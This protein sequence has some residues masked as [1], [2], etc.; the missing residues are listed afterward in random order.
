MVVT[1]QYFPRGGKKPTVGFNDR[2]KYDFLGNADK[3]GKK[4]KYKPKILNNKEDKDLDH[5]SDV[6]YDE[7]DGKIK[8]LSAEKLTY[9]TIQ[10]GMVILGRISEVSETKLSMTLPNRL[11]GSVMACHVSVSYTKLLQSYVDNG[12]EDF[13][14]LEEIY[15][16]GEYVSVKVISVTKEEYKVTIGLSMLPKDVNVGVSFLNVREGDIVRGAVES[17][18]DHGY[19][20]D[21]GISNCRSFLPSK[22]V[23]KSLS[24]VVGQVIWCMVKKGNK[25]TTNSILTLSNRLDIMNSN[26]ITGEKIQH[27]SVNDLRPGMAVDFYVNKPIQDGAEGYVLANSVGYV[28]ASQIDSRLHTGKTVKAYLLYLMP[29]TK[30]PFFTTREIFETFQPDI[31]KEMYYKKGH[32]VENA[33]VSKVTFSVVVFKFENGVGIMSKKMSNCSESENLFDVY[34]TGSEHEIRLVYYHPSDYAYVC[35]DKQNIL[36]QKYFTLEDL[37]VGQFVEGVVARV[38]DKGV[39]VKVDR[40]HGWIPEMHVA[41]VGLHQPEKLDPKKKNLIMKKFKEEDLT[42]LS[43]YEDAKVGSQYKGIIEGIF[44]TSIL[45]K[46][47][48]EVRAIV[49]RKELSHENIKSIKDVFNIGEIVNCVVISVNAQ[50]QKMQGS[51]I[52]PEITL[53]QTEEEIQSEDKKSKRKRKNKSQFSDDGDVSSPPEISKTSEPTK[54]SKKEKNKKAILN[55]A[56]DLETTDVV[57]ATQSK[58]S[59]KKK[60]K[61]E[62]DSL[63]ETENLENAVTKKIKKVAENFDSQEVHMEDNHS[64]SK[65]KSKKTKK[66]KNSDEKNNSSNSN[67]FVESENIES[68]GKSKNKK[69]KIDE[70]SKE[71]VTTNTKFSGMKNFWDLDAST[72]SKNI[73]KSLDNSQSDSDEE[74]VEEIAKK[75]KKRLTNSEKIDKA[76]KEE[77]NLRDIERELME[78]DNQPKSSDQFDR[79]L[80][81]NPSNSELWIAYMAFH[82]QAT[83]ID[84]ARAIAKKAINTISFREEHEKMNVWLALLNLEN[85]FGTKESLNSTLQDAVQMNDSYKIHSKMLDMYVETGKVNELSSLVDLMLAKYKN[86]PEAYT[87]AGEACY[88]L[89]LVDKARAIMQKAL[90]RLD[91]KKHVS[92]LI[93]FAHC[94]NFNGDSERAETLFEQ[95]VGCMPNRVDV[96]C[97]YVDMLLKNQKIDNAR[98]VLERAISQKLQS[99]KMKILYKKWIDMEEKF[100]DADKIEEVR[101]MALNYIEK[102]ID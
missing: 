101:Q 102:V 100:G 5:L 59:K 19:V 91:K 1:E 79:L 86:N 55:N 48:G 85:R 94:E 89:T 60:S 23:E 29:I 44:Q 99:R 56:D 21:I 72:I 54:K 30:L 78:S 12:N 37:Q 4:K 77:E 15:K 18:E 47:F 33:K 41:D 43:S 24:L 98:L 9:K 27:Y 65:K 10:E 68:V 67:E 80:L 71:S 93:K 13:K 20:I 3:I 83:E 25:S 97:V 40:L 49:H 90:S 22:F 76:R 74:V 66:N 82:L 34:K 6:S 73:V 92:V 35:S 64:D 38:M 62:E 31:D 87:Q 32:I 36:Q 51:L 50:E 81:A 45:V 84:R 2:K 95:I 88:K 17:I 46:F 11:L 53:D 57:P 52:R 39:L 26:C 61:L 42:I 14:T 58:K 70:D 63:N 8:S 69:R 7:D 28:H 16:V 96:W 75:K